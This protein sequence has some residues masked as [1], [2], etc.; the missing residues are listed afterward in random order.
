MMGGSRD[1]HDLLRWLRIL[2]RSGHILGVCVYVGARFAGM[3]NHDL[4]PWLALTVLTGTFLVLSDLFQGF[5]WLREI[6]GVGVLVKLALLAAISVWPRA[7]MALLFAV[8][9][10]AGIV[11]HMPGHYRYWVIGRG[12][13]KRRDA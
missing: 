7:E 6:R 11:S 8:I 9:G 5:V 2:C 1:P 4:V 10:I 3:S 13:R 12:P